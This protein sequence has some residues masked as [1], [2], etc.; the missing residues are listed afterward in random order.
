VHVAK[1]AK[2]AGVA[3]YVLSSSCSV[4]GHGDREALDESCDPIPLTNYARANLSAERNTLALG[5]D[6]FTCSVIRNA[7]V[8]GL[9][10]RMRFDLVVNL[11][12]LNA[13]QKG[14]IFIVG[15]GRQWRPLVHVSDVARAFLAV[16]EAKPERVAGEIFNIGID[17]YRVMSIAY[18]VREEIPFRID[19][20]VAPDDADKRDY[21]V[22]FAKMR[23]VL[24][25][26]PLATVTDG[27]H[28]IYDALKMGRVSATPETITVGW[29][30]AIVEAE[31]LV[32]RVRLKGRLI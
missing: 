32:N 17:N 2:A 11:M 19:I 5:D 30:R 23:N 21:N 28:E 22:S 25:F 20:E 3:R 12:T 26:K 7:T 27:I 6:H 31:K 1:C 15:G 8:F 24:G 9:A 18:M 13:V 10:P 29:Y 4:Y 14:K 16:F